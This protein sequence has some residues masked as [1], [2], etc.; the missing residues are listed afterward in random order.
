MR[1]LIFSFF[2]L[3]ACLAQPAVDWLKVNPETLD[4][5][6]N[7][8]K[9]DTTNPP[10]NETKAVEYIKKVLDREG[11]SYEV[12]ALDAN[13]ANIVARIKGN[14]SKR[15][16]IVMGHTDTVGVQKEKWTVDPWGAVRKNGFIYGRGAND[17]K[18]NL[19]A[20][21][22]IAILA[23]RMKVALDRDII[24]I[25]ESGEEGSSQFGIGHL[26]GQHW[27]AI[28]A[29]YCLAE[30][31]NTASR[32][33]RVRY[34]SIA[35]TEKVGRGVKLVAHGIAG[36]G[37]VPREDNPVTH[38]AAAVAK[39]GQFQMPMRLNDTTRAYF[40]RLATI[41]PPD[42]ADRYNH[43]ADAARGEE[44]QRYLAKNE[45]MH[46]SML[47][48]SIVPTMITAG[49]RQNVIPSEAEAT[50]DIRA[51]PDEDTEKLYATIRQ[52][53]N[54]PAVEVV[55]RGQG[56]RPSPPPSKLDTA[57]FQALEK[58][59]KSMFPGAVT[60]PSM[61]T[62]ATD[63]A[64]LRARGVQCYGVGPIVDENDRVGAAH[65]DDER[66]AEASLYKLVEYMWNAVMEVSA[67]R[68]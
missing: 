5:Y 28:N 19:T 62:G 47:R 34:V 52:V 33:G 65:T 26:A 56:T 48:T 6:S 22:M 9:I 8:I 16:I 25:A 21:L 58:V 61:L 17:D 11:I 68:R 27:D 20:S 23:K 59:T 41:S 4:H 24:F 32:D 63:M 29:E 60:L 46:N 51:V 57:M 1:H 54:D 30:G 50:L 38:L 36:H 44:I 15:P 18:D 2:A 55:A 53:V 40:E 66:L 64:Q 31:G 7:L 67:T 13:R 3:S 12:F 10:G 35:T 37:S 49:F 43:L 14:G 45:L 39:I 42:E